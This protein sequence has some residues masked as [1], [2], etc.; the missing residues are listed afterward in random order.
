MKNRILTLLLVAFACGFAT[1]QPLID[2]EG[3]AS[4]FS[5]APMEDI[6]AINKEVIGAVDLE[7]GTVAVSM[8]IKKFTFDRSLMQEHFNENYLES[9]KF[10]KATFKGVIKDFTTLDFTKGGSFEALAEGEMEIHGV[11]KPLSSVV[12]FDVTPS[13]LRA[14]TVFEISIADHD[15][16]IPKLV[17]KNIAEVVEVKAAF[18]FKREQR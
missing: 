5:E 14:E 1:A 11:T 9:E 10:P 2:R 16:E 13:T 4:F 8:F 6:E 18:N 12:K 7:K 17:I 15:I 3:T